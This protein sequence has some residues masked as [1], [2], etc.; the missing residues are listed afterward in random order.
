MCAVRG[1]EVASAIALSVIET[2][3]SVRLAP[4][5]R[6]GR[7]RLTRD[8]SMAH[9]VAMPNPGWSAA[10]L[11][12]LATIALVASVRLAGKAGAGG[13]LGPGPLLADINLVFEIVLVLG[14]TLGML[15]ARR[16]NIEAHRRNQ[17]TW[18]LVNLVFV[19]FLMAGSIAGFKFNGLRDFKDPGLLATWLHAGIG[20]LTAL[21]GTWL[22][23]QMNDLLPQAWHVRRWKVLM[24]ATLAGYWLVALLGLATYRSWYAT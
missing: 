8:A 23:L 17:T 22:V 6:Q 21:A 15:L 20:C 11:V 9:A 10:A 14:L 1:E 7:R 18:V 2:R 12:V 3:L 24:R 5:E 19:V 4:H 16:G 13:F